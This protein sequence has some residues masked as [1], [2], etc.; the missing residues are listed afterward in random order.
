[1]FTGVMRNKHY[2]NDTSMI[3]SSN[4]CLSYLRHIPLTKCTYL[5]MEFYENVSQNLKGLLK[6]G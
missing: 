4:S 1:M 5:L 2:Q 6:D 3:Q